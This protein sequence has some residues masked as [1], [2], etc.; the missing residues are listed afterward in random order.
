[1]TDALP[2]A[3]SDDRSLAKALRRQLAT[4]EPETGA[5]EWIPSA[6]LQ[7]MVA[8]PTARRSWHKGAGH[9]AQRAQLIRAGV[10]RRREYDASSQT[11]RALAGL[12]RREPMLWDIT[13]QATFEHYDERK[14]LFSDQ[15]LVALATDPVAYLDA[16]PECPGEFVVA[17][18]FALG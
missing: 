9:S 13:L 15:D 11:A 6:L 18:A 5:P 2:M 17:V 16:H 3:A 4:F 12:L 7:H 14:Q 10:S 1:M 8:L